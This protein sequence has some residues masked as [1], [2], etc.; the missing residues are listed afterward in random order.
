M[1][2]AHHGITVTGSDMAAAMDDFYYLENAARYQILALSSGEKLKVID[3]LVAATMA[4]GFQ[5]DVGQV[6]GHFIAIQ[7]VLSREEPDYLD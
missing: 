4:P 5:Q 2:M 3:D 1:L 7:R 6:Q